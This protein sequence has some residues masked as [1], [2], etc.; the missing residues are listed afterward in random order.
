MMKKIGTGRATA[1]TA[2]Q[3]WWGSESIPLARRAPETPL[4]GSITAI[5]GPAG[6]GKAILAARLMRASLGLPNPDALGQPVTAANRVVVLMAYYSLH[7]GKSDDVYRRALSPIERADVDHRL[8]IDIRGA[9]VL[10]PSEGELRHA[11]TTQTLYD[12]CTAAGLRAGDR[13]IID[14]VNWLLDFLSNPQNL[15]YWNAAR[16]RVLAAGIDIIE[17]HD[18]GTGIN[19]YPFAVG[20]NSILELS[21]TPGAPHVE[22]THVQPID[23]PFGPCTL[24]YDHRNG[25]VETAVDWSDITG[26]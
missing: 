10:P 13:L 20:A 22:I 7:Y 9:A 17:L 4:Q 16:Q 15:A 5:C 18:R 25:R 12:A 14:T 6:I 26:P 11:I 1:G 24:R 21:G 2:P 8:T 23:K 19:P 3:A